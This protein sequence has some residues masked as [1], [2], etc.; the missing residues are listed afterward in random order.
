MNTPLRRS[1]MAHIVKGSHSFTCT[2]HI[3][4]LTEWTTLVFT[5]QVLRTPAV[6]CN[7]H[8]VQYRV[9]MCTVRACVCVKWLVWSRGIDLCSMWQQIQ[10]GS[11]QGD[12]TQA[13]CYCM[14]HD[15]DCVPCHWTSQDLQVSTTNVS[16]CWW[17]ARSAINW[18]GGQV[19]LSSFIWL[20][21]FFVHS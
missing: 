15:T 19:W 3:H 14:W 5:W 16:A 11:D 17:L 13:G 20:L 18:K 21:S 1:G 7:K 2:P 12:G 10:S 9:M 4:P 8:L 6:C